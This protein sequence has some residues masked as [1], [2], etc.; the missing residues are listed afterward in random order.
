VASLSYSFLVL[1]P[2]QRSLGESR[3]AMTI[4]VRKLE[5]I[6]TTAIVDAGGCCGC[7]DC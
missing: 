7:S 1:T 2:G 5:R 4:V 6:E 3:E